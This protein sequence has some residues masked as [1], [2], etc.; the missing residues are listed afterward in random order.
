MNRPDINLAAWQKAV[1]RKV[2]SET[3][4]YAAKNNAG[5]TLLS[6]ERIFLANP[7]F[8]TAAFHG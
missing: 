8:L 5:N 2:H 4:F 3:T 7:G 1:A 6:F